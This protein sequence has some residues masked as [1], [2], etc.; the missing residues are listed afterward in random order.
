[1]KKGQLNNIHVNKELPNSIE[2]TG[3]TVKILCVKMYKSQRFKPSIPNT[4]IKEF[5]QI[6]NSLT[7]YYQVVLI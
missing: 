2:K 3:Q 6:R 4:K 5:R 7:C 1:M